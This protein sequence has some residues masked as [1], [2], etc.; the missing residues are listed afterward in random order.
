M[1]LTTHQILQLWDSQGLTA[2]VGEYPQPMSI[3]FWKG[4]SGEE[5]SYAFAALKRHFSTTDSLT[6]TWMGAGVMSPLF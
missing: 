1:E 3:H 6:G 4:H 5:L 2:L